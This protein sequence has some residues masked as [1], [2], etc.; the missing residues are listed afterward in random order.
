VNRQPEPA[1]AIRLHPGDVVLSDLVLGRVAAA[2]PVPAG[3]KVTLRRIATGGLG[4]DRLRTP[5]IQESGGTR[6][7]LDRGVAELEAAR[8]RSRRVLPMDRGHHPVSETR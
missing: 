3:H 2:G 5:G 6:A 8:Q 7:A 1:G 4:A